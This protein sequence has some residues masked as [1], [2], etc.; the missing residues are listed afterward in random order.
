[1]K[2]KATFLVLAMFCAT[3]M[4]GQN[5]LNLNLL[6]KSNKPTS[7]TEHFY[8]FEVTN[9]AEGAKLVD[10]RA[11]NSNACDFTGDTCE[12][13]QQVLDINQTTQIDEVL[14]EA[15]ES[16]KFYVKITRPENTPLDTWN[17]TKVYAKYKNN[18]VHSN[19][20]Y[21]ESFV[22]NPDNFN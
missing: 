18:Q 20:V 12:L 11:K 2:I 15:R 22:P 9:N 4:F 10:L 19:Y 14:L 16:F 21:I 7:T 13:I 8:L 5:T 1:M 17:C 3:Y 6:E